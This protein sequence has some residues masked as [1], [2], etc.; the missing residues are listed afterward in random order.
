[1]I[2]KGAEVFA[3]EFIYP[4]AEFATDVA[5]LNLSFSDPSD[6]VTLKDACK[7]KVSYKFI[8]KRLERLGHTSP[9][10]FDGVQFQKLQDQMFGVP[11]YRLR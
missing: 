9:G 6:V 7:A 8:C 1:L 4:E 5:R 11:F 2:E 3:A 10:Q